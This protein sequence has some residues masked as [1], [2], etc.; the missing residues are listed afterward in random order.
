ML[1]LTLHHLWPCFTHG[2]E[3]SGDLCPLCTLVASLVVAV[4]GLVLFGAVPQASFPAVSP[5]EP[6]PD[7]ASWAVWSRRGPP[8]GLLLQS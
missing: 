8:F 6:A 4:G 2:L 1:V 7:P 3:Q 5:V